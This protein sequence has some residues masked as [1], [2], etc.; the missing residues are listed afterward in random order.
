MARQQQTD[1][2]DPRLEGL[3]RFIKKCLKDWE[4]PGVAVAVVSGGNVIYAR[5]FGFRNVRRTLPVDEET[6]FAI[7]SCTKAFTAT[8]AGILVDEEK[9]EWDQPVR[10]YAPSFRLHDTVATER[11]TLRDLLSHRTG[12]P[13]HDLA[14]YGG[15][16]TRAELFERLR[17]LVPTKDFRSLFQYQNLM[18]MSAGIVVEQ[19][20]GGTWEEFARAR[21]L[22]PLGMATSTFSVNDLAQNKNAATGFLR[23]GK[24]VTRVPYRNIDSIGPAGSINS[25]V[26]E[27]CRWVQC[28]LSGGKAGRKRIISEKNLKEIHSPHTVIPESFAPLKYK[29]LLHPT[30]ALGWMEVPY[31][32]FRLLHHGGGIDGFNA[33]VS[34]MPSENVGVVVLTNITGSPLTSV[35]PYNIY[36]RLLGLEEVPWNTRALRERRKQESKPK[37]RMVDKDRKKGTRTSA[38]LKSYAGEY[39]HPGYGSLSVTCKSRR[40]TARFNSLDFE[41][42]HYHHD[43]FSIAVKGTG[44]FDR[45][46]KLKFELDKLGKIASVRVP[47]EATGE[48]I[49]FE[50]A[51]PGEGEESA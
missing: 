33:H 48:D 16:A 28:Q 15:P 13:R 46:M 27:M 50:K 10:E 2:T 14:W 51:E 43:V 8:T 31:R 39:R 5:G 17:H 29:E 25:N 38:P 37:K 21:I 7:G 26:V 12:L 49:V 4:V 11:T 30:Y 41:L 44:F 22:D 40:L 45:S 47:L 6:H 42:K 36:D 35:I 24:R 32:G 9:L 19:V 1:D 23:K 34:F 20:T 18:F 3:D